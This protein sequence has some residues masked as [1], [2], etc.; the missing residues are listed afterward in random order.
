MKGELERL[1]TASPVQ[2]VVAPLKAEVAALKAEVA[3]LRAKMVPSDIPWWMGGK[4][5]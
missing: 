3:Q 1:K 5:K 4:K 2:A